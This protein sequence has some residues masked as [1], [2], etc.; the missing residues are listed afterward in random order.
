MDKK[1]ILDS[2]NLEEIKR[3]FDY[4]PLKG[5][6]TNPSLVYKENILNPIKHFHEI[7]RIIGESKNLYIQVTQREAE[8]IIKQAIN[9]K[10]EFGKNIYV[11]IPSTKEGIKAM[12]GLQGKGINITAT[13]IY[14][15]AQGALAAFSGAKSLA[16]YYNRIESNFMDGAKT[17][18]TLNKII[19]E[20][21]TECEIIAASF[22]SPSQ[23]IT[24]YASGA[25]SCTVPF[26]VLESC[27]TNPL[28]EEADNNFIKDWLSGDLPLNWI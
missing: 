20:E 4:F 13:L 12:K 6:T 18:S 5:V 16:L 1:L 3:A 21:N 28:F 22:K 15:P 19:G 23:V 2:A 9:I 25:H 8:S 7:Q 17:I 27:F 11:K 10:N 26:S 14:T 24:A